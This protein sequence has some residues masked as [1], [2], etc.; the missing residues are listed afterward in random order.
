MRIP[1]PMKIILDYCPEKIGQTVATL[2][3]IEGLAYGGM[4]ILTLAVDALIRETPLADNWDWGFATE[5]QL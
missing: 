3:G 1:E 5:T 4:P 2:A